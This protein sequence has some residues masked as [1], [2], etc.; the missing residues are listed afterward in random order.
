MLEGCLPHRMLV[1]HI[2]NYLIE[3]KLTNKA[4]FFRWRRTH[5]LQHLITQLNLVKDLFDSLS[6]L[7]FTSTCGR[8][9]YST[10]ESFVRFKLL[11]GILAARTQ[12]V[13]IV[14]RFVN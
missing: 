9:L 4:L 14:L 6:L 3:I 12:L 11:M 7:N 1:S 5:R 8:F 10:E 13:L 2:I